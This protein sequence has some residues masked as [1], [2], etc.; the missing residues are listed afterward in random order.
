MSSPESDVTAL[1]TALDS[2][3]RDGACRAAIERVLD[4]QEQIAELKSAR[5][6]QSRELQE[7]EIEL[8]KAE[9]KVE[10]QRSQLAALSNSLQGRNSE[11]AEMQERLEKEKTESQEAFGIV[12]TQLEA[13]T[14]RLEELESFTSKLGSTSSSSV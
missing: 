7:A 4:M 13:K 10:K 11:L 14:R 8:Q 1:F 3:T 6:L 9:K 5:K 12:T 2:L